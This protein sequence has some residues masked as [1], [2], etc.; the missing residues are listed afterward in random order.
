MHVAILEDNVVILDMLT[1]AMTLGG[2]T[3]STYTLASDLY[4]DLFHEGGG[5]NAPAPYDIL[6]LDYML[7]EGLTGEDVVTRIRETYAPEQ[8]P[9]IVISGTMQRHLVDL[10]KRYPDVIV[11]PKPVSLE[12]LFRMMKKAIAQ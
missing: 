3:T 2:H 10:H 8:L 4:E 6:L 9:I 5:E 7:P 1:H 11:I 12:F